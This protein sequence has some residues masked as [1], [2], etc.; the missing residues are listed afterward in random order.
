MIFSGSW[1]YLNTTK[2]SGKVNLKGGSLSTDERGRVLLQGVGSQG[3]TKDC[4]SFV[5]EN[6]MLAILLEYQFESCC[7]IDFNVYNYL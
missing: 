2:V 3:F 1:P 4:D 7:A 6:F 5:T